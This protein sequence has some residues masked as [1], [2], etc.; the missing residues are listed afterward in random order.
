MPRK[1]AFEAELKVAANGKKFN[2]ETVTFNREEL[3]KLE[4]AVELDIYGAVLFKDDAHIHPG[5]FMTA[6]KNFLKNEGVNFQFNTTVIGFKK[7]GERVTEVITDNGVFVA[8]NILLCAGSWL[9][10]LAKCWVSH[11][12]WKVE[13]GIVILTII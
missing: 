7:K 11:C 1:K 5:K 13:K 6:M 3:Q 2:L 12:F 8:D 9:P 10:Q 4:P